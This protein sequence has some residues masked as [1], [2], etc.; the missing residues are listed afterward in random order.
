MKGQVFIAGAFMMAVLL[1]IFSITLGK[2][3]SIVEIPHE[4][5]VLDNAAAEYA[6]SL[7]TGN[8]EIF[9]DYVINDGLKAF[10]VEIKRTDSGFD[11][12]IGNYFDFE[13]NVKINATNAD[14]VR[15][16]E[17]VDARSQ[18]IAVFESSGDSEISVEYIFLGHAYNEKI[19]MLSSDENKLFYHITLENNGLSLTRRN[20]IVG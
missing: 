17:S 10:Y 2:G 4:K 12:I 13:I 7:E 16:Q 8:L 9:S 19:I 14:P 18:R 5:Y 6:Y 15:F 11:A 3:V 1:V 20:V